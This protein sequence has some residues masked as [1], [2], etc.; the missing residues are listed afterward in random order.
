MADE[1]AMQGHL[2]SLSGLLTI[3]RR[4]GEDAARDVGLH[5]LTGW[6]G[7]TAGRLCGAAGPLAPLRASGVE[8]TADVVAA[9]LAVHPLFRPAT[10]ART[11]VAVDGETVRLDLGDG[12][13]FDE[14]SG[15]SWSQLLTA[16]GS[17][18]PIE[19]IVREVDP[20]LRVSA[21]RR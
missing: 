17:V 4:H 8:P 9:L 21:P 13:A 16:S 11:V 14:P 2:L 10:L 12:L 20:T 19:A 3:A 15:L 1:V 5:Q 7:I 6:A 18:A